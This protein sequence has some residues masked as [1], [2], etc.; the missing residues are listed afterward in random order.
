MKE[1]KSR[2]D[3]VVCFVALL[4]LIKAGEIAVTQK[5]VFDDI[6]VEKAL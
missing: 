3:V 6:E 2:T 1:T 5:G 4:E